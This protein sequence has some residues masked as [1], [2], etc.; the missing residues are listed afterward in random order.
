M[1]GRSSCASGC[2]AYPRLELGRA[3]DMPSM[4]STQ[5]TAQVTPHDRAG[6]DPLA[7]VRKVAVTAERMANGDS[8][9]E[10]DTTRVLAGLIH[11]LA[12]QVERLSDPAGGTPMETPKTAIAPGTSP[13]TRVDHEAEINAEEDRSPERGPAE[14]AD[15]PAARSETPDAPPV[16]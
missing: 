4:D 7:E 8:P 6:E 2:F 5:E 14:P 15:D 3:G 10:A 16:R 9:D 11:Q 1:I 13:P 12:E